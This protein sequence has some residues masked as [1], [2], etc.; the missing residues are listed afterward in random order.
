VMNH[1]YSKRSRRGPV[2]FTSL[3]KRKSPVPGVGRFET[4]ES[5][6]SPGLAI[7]EIFVI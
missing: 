2:K 4:P 6:S 3:H 5:L 7:I 1:R